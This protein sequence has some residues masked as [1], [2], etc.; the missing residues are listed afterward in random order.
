MSSLIRGNAPPS[1]NT[2]VPDGGVKPYPA[3][4]FNDT[5][6]PDDSKISRKTVVYS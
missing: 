1:G 2:I 3:C 5:A 6:R 4:G